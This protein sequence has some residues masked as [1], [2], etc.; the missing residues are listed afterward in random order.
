M[1][2]KPYT[3]ETAV[4]EDGL[5]AQLQIIPLVDEDFE[6]AVDD[7]R[8]ALNEA[9]ITHGVKD[10]VLIEI[11]RTKHL[12][13]WAL[14]AEGTAPIAGRD[15]EVRFHF[16]KEKPSVHLKEDAAGRVNLWDLNII[17][18]VNQGD[19][20]CELIPALTG[21]YGTSV[22]GEPIP[23][24]DGNAVTMPKG[25]NVEISEDGT[26]MNATVCG[27]VTFDGEKVIVEHTYTVDLVDASTGN[28]RFIGSVVVNGEVG[29]GFEV[30]AGEDLTIAMSV[31]HVTL[32]AGRDV[33]IAG[34]VLKGSITAGRDIALKFIQDATVSAQ[35]SIVVEDYIQNSEVIAEGPILVKNPSGWIMGGAVSSEQWIYSQM[36]GKQDASANTEIIIG[37]H[38]NLSH[39][40][41]GLVEEIFRRID[42]FQQ[43]RSSLLK[44]RAIKAQ[45]QLSPKQAQLYDKILQAINY[46]RTEILAKQQTVDEITA[47]IQ[48]TYSGEIYAP[49]AAYGGTAIQIGGRRKLIEVQS[50]V[51][52]FSLAEGQIKEDAF[53]MRKEIEDLLGK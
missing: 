15:G 22:K 47:R 5:T 3:I 34:G 39:V 13:T 52:K 45:G 1:D 44:M 50:S 7:L 6:V 25:T 36:I 31:G 21:T 10:D 12:N 18:N 8:S 27:M 53:S 49:G 48:R 23:A 29:D 9:G 38:P 24:T 43:F 40:R 51:I 41:T 4:S 26:R 37:S 20:L 32:S 11:A 42:D 16:S 2:E 33:K 17:Q 19:L 30:H 14:V 35:G 28:I 46:V